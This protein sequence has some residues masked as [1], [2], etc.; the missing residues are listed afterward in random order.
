MILNSTKT[1]MRSFTLQNQWLP[2]FYLPVL[3]FLG[4]LQQPATGSY[5]GYPACFI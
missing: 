2:K 4:D 5:N 1:A 3:H